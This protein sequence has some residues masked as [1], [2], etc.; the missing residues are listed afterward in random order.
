MRLGRSHSWKAV[1]RRLSYDQSI[2]TQLALWNHVLHQIDSRYVSPG[3]TALPASTPCLACSVAAA[4]AHLLMCQVEPLF[5]CACSRHAAPLSTPQV[6][7]PPPP[8]VGLSLSLPAPARGHAAP[9][10]RHKWCCYLPT[11]GAQPLFACACSRACCSPSTP[12]FSCIFRSSSS[13]S[14]VLTCKDSP[15]CE[16]SCIQEL[17]LLLSPCADLQTQPLC[18]AWEWPRRV[19]QALQGSSDGFQ[20]HVCCKLRIS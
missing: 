2:S 4:V 8:H 6:V 14:R 9:H 17:L 11:S 7:L 1:F 16:P 3:N 15:C 20:T 10:P 18:C 12:Y 19:Q 5:P 13:F